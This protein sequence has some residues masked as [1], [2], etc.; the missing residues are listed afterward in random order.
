MEG[1]PRQN[2]STGSCSKGSNQQQI[3]KQISQKGT[4]KGSYQDLIRPPV[5]QEP[6]NTKNIS[7]M[8]IVLGKKNNHI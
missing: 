3:V 4:I 5:N 8:F 7:G 2:E 6:V 1:P